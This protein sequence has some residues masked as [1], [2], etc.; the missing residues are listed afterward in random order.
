MLPQAKVAWENT[1]ACKYV[2]GKLLTEAQLV[3]S[4]YKQTDSVGIAFIVH[5]NNGLVVV[6]HNEKV[7]LLAEN[8]WMIAQAL[9]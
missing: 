6:T 1:T 7:T 2:E 4:T 3:I 9:V 8:Q 5:N